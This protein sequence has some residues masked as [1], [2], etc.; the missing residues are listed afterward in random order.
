[1]KII[2]DSISRSELQKIADTLF[3]NLVKAVV[4]IRKEILAVGGEMHA[5]EERLL[6]EHGSKQEDL[7]GINLYPAL[8]GSDFIEYDSMINVR[9]TQKNLSRGVD[10]PKIRGK[11]ELI[12][13]K[14]ITG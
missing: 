3:G 2:T 9:P 6:L 4:D 10:D 11:I 8:T 5:D 1:M 14:R 13:K 7:W 12:I